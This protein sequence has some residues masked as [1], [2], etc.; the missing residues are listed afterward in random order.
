MQKNETLCITEYIDVYLYLD[1][2]E[3]WKILL[4]VTMTK[5]KI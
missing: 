1:K 2:D 3:I 5:L 4:N